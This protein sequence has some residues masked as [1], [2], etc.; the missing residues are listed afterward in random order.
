MKHV[1]SMEKQDWNWRPADCGSSSD[2]SGFQRLISTWEK[3]ANMIHDDPWEEIT[4]FLLSYCLSCK[5]TADKGTPRERG[6]K[7]RAGI[8]HRLLDTFYLLT[9]HYCFRWW[10]YN[11]S[12]IALILQ[13]KATFVIHNPPSKFFCL[14]LSKILNWFSG[15]LFVFSLL[16]SFSPFQE[17]HVW[18]FCSLA[19]SNCFLVKLISA[20][21]HPTRVT[22]LQM[23][24]RRQA[25]SSYL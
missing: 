13:G 8:K 20:A 11:L 19:W 1:C 7:R 3:N 6:S 24:K 22:E 12:D 23:A 18:F 15:M 16:Q 14:L 21:C 25:C 17:G 2:R 9:P 5:Y 10:W 4:F